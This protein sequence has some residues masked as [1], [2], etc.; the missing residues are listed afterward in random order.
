SGLKLQGNRVEARKWTEKLAKRCTLPGYLRRIELPW[1]QKG[2]ALQ[3]ALGN[4]ASIHRAV[5]VPQSIHKKRPP[6]PACGPGGLKE[7]RVGMNAR[8]NYRAPSQS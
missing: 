3:R 6:G 8:G 1:F 4:A 7:L 5:C 2:K